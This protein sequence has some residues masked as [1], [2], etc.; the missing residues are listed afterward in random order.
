MNLEAVT[1]VPETKW[2]VLIKRVLYNNSCLPTEGLSLLQKSLKLILVIIKHWSILY[3]QWLLLSTWQNLKPLGD[4]CLQMPVKGHLI[5]LMDVGSPAP[6]GW[7]H[8]LAG[9]LHCID[10]GRELSSSKQSLLPVPETVVMWTAAPSF[11]CLD[12]PHHDGLYLEPWARTNHFGISCLFPGHFITQKCHLFVHLP[13]C[14]PL[15][16]HRELLI[17]ARHS[18]W[19]VWKAW[20]TTWFLRCL[21]GIYK[22]EIHIFLCEYSWCHYFPL[23]VSSRKLLCLGT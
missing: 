2:W 19:W 23:V 9:I 18:G 21:D 13:D 12:S 3:L 15:L 7:Y 10:G 8:P 5:L 20:M 22:D 14:G 17:L 11:S 1:V 4:R 6:C 16:H